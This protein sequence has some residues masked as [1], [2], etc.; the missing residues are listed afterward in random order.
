MGRSRQPGLLTCQFEI[1]FRARAYLMRERPRVP[2]W[3]AR[4]GGGQAGCPSMWGDECL[5]FFMLRSP[6]PILSVSCRVVDLG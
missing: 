1:N 3:E 6:P 4:R 2:R 5:H